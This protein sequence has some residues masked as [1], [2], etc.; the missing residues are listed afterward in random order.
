MKR[1]YK[2]ES[3]QLHRTDGPAVEDIYGKYW[4]INGELH[5]TDG[6]AI[7]WSDGSKYW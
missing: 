7:E 5:R 2:N 6:P 4:Y 1:E 3:G